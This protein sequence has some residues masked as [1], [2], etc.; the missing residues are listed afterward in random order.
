MT[1]NDW[2][3]IN[4][5]GVASVIP[6]KEIPLPDYFVKYFSLNDYNA[7]A[8]LKSYLYFSHPLILNDPFDSC[9]QLVDLKEFSERQLV[10]LY[11]KNLR[12]SN[13]SSQMSD[14]EIKQYIA[15]RFRN[16][17]EELLDGFL[18]LF[19]NLIFKDW[20]IMS[21]SSN[22]VNMLMWSYYNNHKGFSIRFKNNLFLKNEI[23]GPFPINYTD[24]YLPISPQSIRI[25][26]E[27]LLYVTNVKSND[28][29]H[30]NEWRYLFNCHDM[31]IPEYKDEQLDENKRKV[32]YDLDKV[33]CII[34]GYKFFFGNIT[35]TY[36]GK[37]KRLYQFKPS[38]DNYN[39]LKLDIINFI[40]DKR[41]LVKEIEI[42]ENNKFELKLVDIII[43]P[44]TEG[45]EY[46]VESDY[47][48]KPSTLD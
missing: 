2:T 28:W 10:K 43:Y 36:H 14:D 37:G 12:Y 5:K 24:S 29:Q 4:K 23:L 26:L 42:E 41:I 25:D 27:E 30:E 47:Y 31:S 17:K 38:K 13:P 48:R 16:D 6:N 22:P 44:K 8:L 11:T 32:E 21:L 46:F 3:Y 20:G 33:D 7:D 45:K 9:R 39:Q 40:I 19:W 15:Y 34:L 35:G 18:T 1:F